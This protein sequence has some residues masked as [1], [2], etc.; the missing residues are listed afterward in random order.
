MPS[1]Q[2]TVSRSVSLLARIGTPKDEALRIVMRAAR[3]A[4]GRVGMTAGLEQCWL[5]QVAAIAE[6]Q[7]RSIGRQERPDRKDGS[8][9]ASTINQ[10]GQARQA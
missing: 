7:L 4:A 3:E 2:R 9:N 10:A 1:T 8:D 6:A 5:G